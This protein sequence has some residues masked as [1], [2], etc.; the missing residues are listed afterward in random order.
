MSSVDDREAFRDEVISGM[1]PTGGGEKGG[2]D[3]EENKIK[4]AP[5]PF[6]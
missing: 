3:K 2:D 5:R 1:L 4:W 6:E